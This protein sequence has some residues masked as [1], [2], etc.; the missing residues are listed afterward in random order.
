M[1]IF[2]I[3]GFLFFISCFSSCT[4]SGS[5][6]EYQRPNILFCLADDASFPHMS[7]YGTTWVNT[8]AFDR[9]AKEGV[10]FMNAY[11][12]NAKCAPSRAT[13]LTGR[14]SWQLEE[15]GNHWPYFPAKFKTFMEVLGEHGYFTGHTLKGW[16]PGKPGEENGEKRLLT[17]KAYNDRTLE[18]PT[19]H[20]S[21][22][23]YA[24]NFEDFLNEKPEDEPFCFWY[25]SVEPHRAYEY[26]SSLRYGKSTD[27]IGQVPAFWPDNDTVRTDMLD[28]A[29]ELEYFDQHIGKMLKI[30]EEKGELDNTIIV[31]TSDNGMP[32]PR[33]K[34][35][36]Y[37][38]SNHLP[39]AIM[40]KNGI[41]NVGRKVNDFISFID[42]TPTFLELTEIPFEKS[43]MEAVEG[44]SFTDILFSNKEGFIKAERDHVLIGKERHDVGRPGD[45]GY[46]IR[47]IVKGNFLYV[48]NYENSR[49]PAG[50]PETGYLNTDGGATKT[51][52]LEMRRRGENKEFW[53][54]NF[55]KR[56]EEELYDISKDLNCIH[57]L[58]M[59]PDFV[60]VA[61]NLRKQ[62]E[63]ELKKQGD[64]RM[65]GKGYIFD[66][67]EYANPADVNFYL[68]FIR[69]EAVKAGWV[70]ESDFEK[71]KID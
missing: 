40:W 33:V 51:S 4:G 8:P 52:I 60:H 29:L 2:Y 65:F 10:L 43:G 58:A 27:E 11:T 31:I 17:G 38:M 18:P 49:W 62:M 71:G 59:N 61:N 25:G 69:N 23:D 50:N 68:R 44:K 42:F 35:Q 46:P 22:I 12:P 28:Y 16:A 54:L 13:I 24:A 20:I 41:K 26:G 9:V 64:P 55:G 34:G 15:A 67:Y 36:A 37:E 5:E 57:N 47:G 45:V 39:L 21:K 7:A 1:S 6:P 30:L 3:F 14:N 63:N 70:N 48:K 56:M 32:F 19:E 53:R 66:Q